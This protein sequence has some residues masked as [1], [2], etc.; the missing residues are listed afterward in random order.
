MNTDPKPRIER[1]P[2]SDYEE[3]D[4]A[5]AFHT[6]DGLR[7]Q[8]FAKRT[9]PFDSGPFEIYASGDQ[10]YGL[11]AFLVFHTASTGQIPEIEYLGYP[12]EL[13]YA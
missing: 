5:I 8:V 2:D 1:V 11:A 12:S 13:T 6:S 4:R 7:A 3:A 9:G 10:E